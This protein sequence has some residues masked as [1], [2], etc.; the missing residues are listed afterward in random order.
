[1]ISILKR[2][3]VPILVTTFIT[4]T[5]SVALTVTQP[6]EYRSAFTVLAIDN[7][8]NLDGYAAA[9][10]AERLSQSLGRTIPTT[11]FADSVYA[12][13]KSRADLKD[14]PL[15]SSDVQT[16]RDEWAKR[17][18]VQSV[19]DVGQVRVAVYQADRTQADTIANAISIAVTATGAEYLG[20]GKDVELKIVDTPL[21]T[22]TPVRPNVFANL[23]VGLILGFGGSIAVLLLFATPAQPTMP[24]PY[25]PLPAA[26]YSTL[27][28][29]TPNVTPSPIAMAST[30]TPTPPRPEPKRAVSDTSPTEPELHIPMH[31]AQPSQ[32]KAVP[33]S[34]A[35]LP[36]IDEIVMP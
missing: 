18:T 24:Y 26:M 20:G 36:V 14:N 15:I 2:Y 22:K 8:P 10:S 13:L 28:S 32:P 7:D 16:R 31:P 30:E 19:P 33:S 3:W 12:Q 1:M 21:T 17:V 27:A 23:A 35:N 6:M 11:V 29:P 34:P 4:F 9:K 25:V 5:V